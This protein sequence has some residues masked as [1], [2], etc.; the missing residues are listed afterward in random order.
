MISTRIGQMDVLSVWEM[1]DTWIYSMVFFCKGRKVDT[2]KCLWAGDWLK[3]LG[4]IHAK[5]YHTARK[6]NEETLYILIGKYLQ[7]VFLSEGNRSACAT[8]SHVVQ[9]WEKEIHKYMLLYVWNT[10]GGI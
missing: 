7:Y 4:H 1:M 9:K 3:K 6:M 5:E 10:F 2:P 8:C